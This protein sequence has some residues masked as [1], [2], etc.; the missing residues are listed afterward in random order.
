ML[1]PS[2]CQCLSTFASGTCIAIIIIY[3]M[4]DETGTE[5]DRRTDKRT[6]KQTTRQTK[7][8]RHKQTDRRA[9]RQKHITTE[10]QRDKQT[11]G[12]TN[13]L[14][15]GRSRCFC[16]CIS[17]CFSFCISF[18]LCLIGSPSAVLS[19]S[20]P[21]FP[22]MGGQRERERE[23]SNFQCHHVPPNC[24]RQSFKELHCPHAAANQSLKD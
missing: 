13:R 6:S 18:A 11:N 12:R 16:L 17:L 9:E 24:P 2:P 10:R 15:D 23:R 8:Q 3:D 1:H 14:T 7:R 20:A 4:D 5:T 19:L 21:V 22:T